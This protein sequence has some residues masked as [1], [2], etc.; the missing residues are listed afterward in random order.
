MRARQ[1][2]SFANELVRAPAVFSGRFQA[3]IAQVI[4][5]MEAEAGNNFSL[6]KINLVE[7]E[8][9]T[10]VSRAKLHRLKENG[11]QWIHRHDG[12][13]VEGR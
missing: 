13:H 1:A 8:R 7:L 12:R 9:R 6:E 5:E 11:S 10:G 4:E 2:S 3:A